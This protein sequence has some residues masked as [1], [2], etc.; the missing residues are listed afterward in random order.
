MFETSLD[1]LYLV[2]AGCAVLLTVALSLFIF[3]LTAVLRQVNNIGLLVEHLLDSVER[4]IKLP[5]RVLFSMTDKAK[6]VKDFFTQHSK[7]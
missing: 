7:K 6:S 3:R 1:I 5:A 2:L 4:Y